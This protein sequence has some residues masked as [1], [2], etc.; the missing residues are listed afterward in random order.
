MK[1]SIQIKKICFCFYSFK[2][3][4]L[5]VLFSMRGLGGWTRAD[6]FHGRLQVVSVVTNRQFFSPLPSTAPLSPRW[7]SSVCVVLCL[8]HVS[9]HLF[10]ERRHTHLRVRS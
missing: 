5:F 10:S 1:W 8:F 7:S 6:L 3:L 4:D 9:T 2:V